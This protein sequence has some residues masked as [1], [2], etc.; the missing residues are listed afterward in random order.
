MYVS[1]DEYLKIFSGNITADDWPSVGRKACAYIDRLTFDRL[2]EVKEIP[3][4]VKLAVCAAAESFSTEQHAVVSSVVKS[5]NNDGY[6]E[7]FYS[8]EE[9]AKFYASERAREVDLYL[10]RSHPLRYAGV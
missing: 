8:P 5:F 1:F 6:S 3:L 2:A 4:A 9:A 10:P 7:S